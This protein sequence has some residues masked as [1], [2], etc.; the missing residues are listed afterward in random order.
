MNLKILLY[1]TVKLISR[2]VLDIFYPRECIACNS[3]VNIGNKLSVCRCCKNTLNAR[4]VVIRNS[5]KYFDEAICSFE[6]SGNIKKAMSDFKFKRLTYLA[7]TF[8]YAV[9]DNVKN[10][11]FL[12]SVSFICPVPLHPMRDRDYNQSELIAKELSHYINVKMIPDILIKTKNLPPLSKMDYPKRN[13]MI[14]SSFA[15]NPGHDV[16]GKTIC[17]VDDIYTTSATVNEC[18]R[19]LK[20]HGAKA[21]YVLCP[22]YTKKRKEK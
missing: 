10:R 13:Y 8:A 5:E 21:V 4:S 18:A 2:S 20:M 7:Q 12:H 22:C 11:D 6:Y 1:K 3:F 19:V 14:K 9:Y 16:S 17:L 15:L